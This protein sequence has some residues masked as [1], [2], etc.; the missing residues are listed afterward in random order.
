MAHLNN[1]MNYSIATGSTILV[2]RK[3]TLCVKLDPA[4]QLVILAIAKQIN[5]FQWH[6]S[7]YGKTNESVT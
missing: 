4:V 1:T 2:R 6:L 5:I 3:T 7:I